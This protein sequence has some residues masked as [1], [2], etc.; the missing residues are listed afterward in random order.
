MLTAV[1]A[2]TCKAGIDINESLVPVAGLPSEQAPNCHECASNVAGG[3]RGGGLGFS[4]MCLGLLVE[5]SRERE[6]RTRGRSSL[7]SR[8]KVLKELVTFSAQVETQ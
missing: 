2:Q 7:R 8:I 5:R 3:S 1:M 6:G 4:V